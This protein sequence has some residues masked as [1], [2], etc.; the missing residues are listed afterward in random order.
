MAGPSQ[1]WPLRPASGAR[2]SLP[3]GRGPVSPRVAPTVGVGLALPRARGKRPLAG[4]QPTYQH[5]MR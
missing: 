4:L 2:I 3:P 5:L 1:T